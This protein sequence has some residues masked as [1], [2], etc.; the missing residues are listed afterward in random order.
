MAIHRAEEGMQVVANSVYLLPPKKEMIIVEGRLHLSDKDP[1]KGLALPIDRFLE[2]FAHESG[3]RSIAIILSG[4][5]SDGSRGVAEVAREGG[6]VIIESL[7][8]AKFDGMPS[9]AL[10]SGVVDE[11][12]APEEIGRSLVRLAT[13]PEITRQQ[14][15]AIDAQRH[16]ALR[17]MDAIYHLFRTAHDIDF[18]VYKDTTVL[19]RV[20][21]RLAMIGVDNLD[22]YGQRLQEDSNELD[23]LYSDLL[24]GVTQFFRDPET[25][26][27]L[28]QTVIPELIFAKEEGE[29][30]RAWIS[31][32]ATG[33]E[34]YSM[35]IIFHEAFHARANHL[36]SSCSPPMSTKH[37]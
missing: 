28:E 37:R 29:P 5:G 13:E 17:G 3:K 27:L 34:A 19:R 1:Q 31:G 15:V 24:I 2:S 25:F 36:T 22:D 23:A 12:L 33:E 11:V 9:S 21:R 32:C 26:S 7:E 30:L 10:A 16:D 8:T 20:H 35:A 4:S 18:S 14:R 6:Y